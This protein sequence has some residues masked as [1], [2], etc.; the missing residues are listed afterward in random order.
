MIPYSNT[1]KLLA[2]FLVILLVSASIGILF[3]QHDCADLHC[4]ICCILSANRF[5]L[6][7]FEALCF[8]IHAVQCIPFLLLHPDPFISPT[9]VSEKVKMT[10]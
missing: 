8:G 2:V 9:L 3:T 10:S 6:L 7:P 5:C 1:R 4:P